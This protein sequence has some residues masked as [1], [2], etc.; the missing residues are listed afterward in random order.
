MTIMGLSKEFQNS[1]FWAKEAS[2]SKYKLLEEEQTSSS[3]SLPLHKH[4]EN[5][6]TLTIISTAA[7]TISK[8][9][10]LHMILFMISGA[11]LLYSILKLPSKSYCIEKLSP[12]CEWS[13]MIY[14]LLDG[15]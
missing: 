14:S 4:K 15:D 13:N 2:S 7:S 11:V 5:I 1:F 6:H 9:W 10:I 3:T 12:Y 8:I